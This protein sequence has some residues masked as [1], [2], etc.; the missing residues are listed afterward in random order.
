M[1][2]LKFLLIRTVL[3][4]D[5][6]KVSWYLC[7]A[8]WLAWLVK[9]SYGTGLVCMNM[10]T[11]QIVWLCESFYYGALLPWVKFSCPTQGKIPPPLENSCHLDVQK[12]YCTNFN[13]KWILSDK[14]EV[15]LIGLS[16]QPMFGLGFGNLW[17]VLST[18]FKECYSESL[19]KGS[20]ILH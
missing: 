2:K 3:W 5:I 7:S 4:L 20:E 8:C 16:F 12:T 1:K 15:F 14:H 19:L 10:M 9:L 17:W 6:L 13:F 11:C 18:F